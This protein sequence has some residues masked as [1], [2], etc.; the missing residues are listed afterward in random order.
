MRAYLLERNPS[1]YR[2]GGYTD[3]ELE[4]FHQASAPVED[5]TPITIAIEAIPAL[6]LHPDNAN[7]GEEI[8]HNASE[9]VTSMWQSRPITN[10]GR[11]SLLKVL[12][13][14]FQ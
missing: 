11:D 10:G 9:A 7:M 6:A 12:V 5:I 1:P 13:Y 4:Q 2:L 8:K 3:D 14:T